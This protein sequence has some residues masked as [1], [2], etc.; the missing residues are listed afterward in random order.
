MSTHKLLDIQPTPNVLLALTRTPITP[1]DALCELIDNALDSFRAAEALG[2]PSAFRQVFVEVPGASEVNRGDG[3]VRVRDSGPG[4][5]EEQIANALRAGYSS[6]NAFDT[7]GLFGMGFNIA[8]GKLGRVTKLISARAEDSYALQVTVDLPKLLEQGSFEVP[9]DVVAKPHG[10]EHGTII[11]VRNWWPEGDP[12]NAFIRKLAS[13]GKN[14]IRQQLARRYATILRGEGG[15]RTKIL[16]NNDSYPAFEHCVWDASRFVERAGHGRIPARISFDKELTKNIRCLRDGTL[17]EDGQPCGRCGGSEAREVVERVWGWVGIQ[18]YDDQN[19]YGIDLIRNGRAI[20]IGEKA[21]FFEH[22]DEN[23]KKAEKEYPVDQQYGRIVGEVHLDHVPVDFSKQD[24]QRTSD[25]WYAAMQFLRGSSLIPSK[26]GPGETNPSPV[27]RLFQGYRKVRNFGRADMYM[28]QYN[29]AKGKAERIPRE[30]EREYLSRFQSQEAGYYDDT[31]W[32]ELVESANDK[33]IEELLECPVCGFQNVPR[34]E[35]C[36]ECNCVLVGKNCLNSDCGA[37]IPKSAVSC[38]VCGSSQIPKVI[39]P[40]NC[41]FCGQTNEASE[42]ACRTCALVRGAAHPASEEELLTASEEW[43][44]LSITGL[45]ISLADGTTSSPVDVTTRM[46]QRP[47]VPRYG[48]EP[49]PVLSHKKIGKIAVFVDRMHPAFSEL[50]MRPEDMVAAETAQFFYDNYSSLTGQRG[51]SPGVLMAEVLRR[52]WGDLVAETPESVR[53]EIKQVFRLIAERLVGIPEAEDFYADLDEKQQ[54]ALA[55]GMISSGV[56]LSELNRMKQSGEYLRYCDPAA[57]V[58]FFQKFPQVW[59]DGQVWRDPWPSDDLGPTVAEGLREELSIKYL[60][61]L[62]DCASYL[63]YQ[64]P[65]PL[66]V[67]RARA[68]ADFL[69]S[70]L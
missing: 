70:R 18:R 12:N 53:E 29:P 50:G 44:D 14:V 59:F 33:P 6:K 45:T 19:D 26:W 65:E 68:A 22:V 21:A 20:R 25:E 64:R 3:F 38:D 43:T 54:R 39:T 24:F 56:D 61:C 60:R 41:T 37:E 16:L 57:L 10:L 48:R 28:G 30:I 17:M 69:D 63:R 46:M 31:K 62:E 66:L 9:A 52:A 35:T 7:L 36:E 40:W 2:Q 49:I 11:E 58:M 32:W 4:L 23:T 13:L 1:L 34:V 15:S 47:I 27:S 67:T 55:E 51:H 8:T 5:T 42:D